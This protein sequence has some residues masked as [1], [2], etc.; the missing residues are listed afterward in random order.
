MEGAVL[1]IRPKAMTVA[2]IVAGLI[3]IMLGSGAGSDV[4]QRIAAPMI[5]GM[6]TAPLLSLFVIPVVYYGVMFKR[7]DGVGSALGSLRDG[8]M[9]GGGANG[10]AAPGDGNL[11][12]HAVNAALRYRAQ[13][14]LL[15]SLLKEV[16]LTG[17]DLNGLT[18]ALHAAGPEA[19][20]AAAAE[21]APPLP[22]APTDASQQS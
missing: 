11:A 9:P 4:M 1:R 22:K 17:G 7:L 8:L 15:D 14:P 3:P 19:D 10:H 20:P 6:L 21:P 5:G 2:V 18:Q 13:A 16:G 12:D